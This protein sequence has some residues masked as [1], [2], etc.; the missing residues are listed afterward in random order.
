MRIKSKQRKMLF[1]TTEIMFP[2]H[3]FPDKGVKPDPAMIE[4]ITK[5]PTPTS[6]IKLQP[7]LMMLTYHGKFI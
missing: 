5:M 2:G 4:A 3:L 7:F 1:A 6:K